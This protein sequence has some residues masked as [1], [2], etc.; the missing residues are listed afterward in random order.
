MENFKNKKVCI[1]DES[2][3]Y[4]NGLKLYIE[5]WSRGDCKVDINTCVNRM[6]MLEKLVFV[7]DA[8]LFVDS[9]ILLNEDIYYTIK[10][11]KSQNK[12]S[13]IYLLVNDLNSL[14]NKLFL[15]C[16]ELEICSVISKSIEYQDFKFKMNLSSRKNYLNELSQLSKHF[17][18]ESA[19][20]K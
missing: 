14:S 17:L 18:A 1:L 3:M 12:F 16:N 4:A 2:L 6:E 5:K 19:N 9:K 15:W 7:N 8:M 13:R 10:K 20:F 11:F